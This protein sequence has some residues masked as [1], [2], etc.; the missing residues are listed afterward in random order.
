MAWADF[1]NDL[2]NFGN[3]ILGT[4][5]SSAREQN[6]QNRDFQEKMSNTAWQ[7]GV[8]DMEAAGINPIAAFGSGGGAASTPS[9]NSG[10]AGN[11]NII[12]LVNSALRVA[13]MA[14]KK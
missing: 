14:I 1:G 10:G 6:Q 12:G 13:E 7:R 11:G 2:L 8:K 3:D 9:G 5:G 4:G